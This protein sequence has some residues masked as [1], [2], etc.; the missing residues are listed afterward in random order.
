LKRP[1]TTG[2]P[3]ATEFVNAALRTA[4]RSLRADPGDAYLS[5]LK[6]LARVGL[7]RAECQP[8]E[9]WGRVER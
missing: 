2:L 3:L 6:Y 5:G 8:T 9:A 4:A 7:D 1:P